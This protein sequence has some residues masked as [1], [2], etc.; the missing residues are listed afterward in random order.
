[1]ILDQLWG[2][3]AGGDGGGREDGVAAL[4]VGNRKVRPGWEE[5]GL[6]MPLMKVNLLGKGD[7]IVS[8]SSARVTRSGMSSS[9][10]DYTS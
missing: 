7:W 1:V 3:K 5:I 9:Y 2:F 6:K 4:E 10:R 8:V